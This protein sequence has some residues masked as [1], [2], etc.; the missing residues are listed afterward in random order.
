MGRPV[1][2][3]RNASPRRAPDWHLSFE[4]ATPHDRSLPPGSDGVAVSAGSLTSRFPTGLLL[5][6]RA[7]SSGTRSW[8]SGSLILDSVQR[9]TNGPERRTVQ[10]RYSGVRGSA[11]SRST[12]MDGVS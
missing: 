4:R 10:E 2:S 6:L 9:T 7:V 5:Y 3:S 1:T 12:G 8:E 11:Y